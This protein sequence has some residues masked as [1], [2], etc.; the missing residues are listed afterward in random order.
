[1]RHPH[2]TLFL[3]FTTKQIADIFV[4]FSFPCLNMH[5]YLILPIKL[6]KT[7]EL[8]DEFVK[9]GIFNDLDDGIISVRRVPARRKFRDDDSVYLC[10]S[11]E[12]R[13]ILVFR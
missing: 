13:L 2:K 7:G 10:T 12:F 8:K 6:D 5:L 9:A 11:Y 3:Y 4:P 1:M